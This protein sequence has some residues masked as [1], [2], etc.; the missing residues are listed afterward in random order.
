MDLPYL[1]LKRNTIGVEY[2]IQKVVCTQ[3][4]TYNPSMMVKS[5]LG[6]T[7]EGVFVHPVMS[8]IDDG[9]VGNPTEQL[10][11]LKGM[12]ENLDKNQLTLFSAS[13]SMILAYH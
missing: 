8:V 13:H 10:E 9:K 5:L 2:G 11:E 6:N 12:K 1:E 3:K 7:R 4:T